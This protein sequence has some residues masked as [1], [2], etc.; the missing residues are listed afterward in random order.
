MKEIWPGS[1]FPRG[2]AFDGRGVNF[3]VYSHAATRVEVGL[4]DPADPTREVDR[5]DL[6]EV[7]GH[8]W[9]GYVPELQPGALYGL[10]V[11]GPYAPHRG[12]RCNPNKLLVDPY[13]KAVRGKVDWTQAV[14]GY[15]PEDE[16]A[17]LSFDERDSA[18]GVPKGV[19]VDDRFDW[20]DDRPP[21]TPWRDTIIYETHVRGFTLKQ[22]DLPEAIRGT[23]AGLAH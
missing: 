16:R 20:G 4:Y 17:D 6:P 10:R 7:T 18:P 13:A 15:V 9:H 22:P 12:Q 21:R 3:A 11:H 5:F 1:P 2:A 8:T 19:I 23:Y 14:T